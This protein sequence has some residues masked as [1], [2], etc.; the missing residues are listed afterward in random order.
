[1]TLEERPD[2]SEKA[3]H[4]PPASPSRMMR[5]RS[6]PRMT[7]SPPRRKPSPIARLLLHGKELV[8]DSLADR[9][10]GRVL[11]PMHR[12][13]L[14]RQRAQMEGARTAVQWDPTK[15]CGQLGQ[16]TLG[17]MLIRSERRHTK[18]PMG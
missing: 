1:H 8:E 4:P 7:R 9:L 11:G 3:Q 16:Q 2:A 17:A 6:L 13:P 12:R 18:I 10:V 14:E 15:V 5:R